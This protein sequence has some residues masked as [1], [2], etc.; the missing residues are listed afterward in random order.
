LLVLD[1]A[2]T[3]DTQEEG[4]AVLLISIIFIFEKIKLQ[5]VD[6]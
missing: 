3:Q 2:D 1:T 5:Y 4:L 6:W